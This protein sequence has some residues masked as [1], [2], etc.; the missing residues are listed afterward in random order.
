MWKAIFCFMSSQH[1]SLSPCL[2]GKVMAEWQRDLGGQSIPGSRTLSKESILLTHNMWVYY[3]RC[4]NILTLLYL[5]PWL[6]YFDILLDGE[7]VMCITLVDS[8]ICNHNSTWSRGTSPAEKWVQLSLA[9]W[10]L[11]KL[12]DWS[13]GWSLIKIC[14]I[15]PSPCMQACGCWAPSCQSRS[16]T[17]YFLRLVFLCYNSSFL[18]CGNASGHLLGS[19]AMPPSTYVN[20][21]CFLPGPTEKARQEKDAD[22]QRQSST[23]IIAFDYLNLIQIVPSCSK[24][25]KLLPTNV[26]QQTKPH[27]SLVH[28][29][30]GY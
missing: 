29:P 18:V 7:Q 13:T 15:S 6:I 22:H 25:L 17:N 4:A 8:Y 21:V 10:C 16:S 30:K 26:I 24:G 1:S 11:V 3:S 28:R 9:T 12:G 20:Y 23:G 27:T 14:W 2:D 5:W 19:S